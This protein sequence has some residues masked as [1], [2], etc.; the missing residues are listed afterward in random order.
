[1]AIW[2]LGS[3]NIDHVY[4]VPHLPGPGETLAAISYHLGLG[5]KG[6]NQSIAAARAG[7]MVHH[8]GAVGAGAEWVLD[9]MAVAG[10]DT[11]QIATV[12]DATGHAIINVD[13]MGE[14][15]IVIHGGANLAQS[16]T[17]IAAALER[18]EPGD[19]LLMQNE[20]SQQAPTARLA[21]ERGLRVIYSAAPFAAEAVRAVVS[22]VSVLVVNAV[23][24][25][26]LQDELG[27]SLSSLPV[28]A[29]VITRGA[30]GAEWCAPGSEPVFVPAFAVDAVDST[31]AG[32]CFTGTLAAALDQGMGPAGAMRRAAAAAALQVTRPGAADAM[33]TR[34]EVDA[35]LAR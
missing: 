14:N 6:A 5:G 31:G 28:E 17:R 32:D 15:A 4:R 7:A 30:H 2:T 9:R 12:G 3:I 27:V 11:S 21:R 25:R 18:A 8:L 16:P 10:V 1:M 34:D 29:V 24:A 35:F 23:E 20:T 26:Q 33:P 13:P 22:D 19:I